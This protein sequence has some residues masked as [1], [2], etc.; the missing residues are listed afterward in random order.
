MSDNMCNYK[1]NYFSCKV[2]NISKY[3]GTKYISEAYL[4]VDKVL[5][6]FFFKL[7]KVY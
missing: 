6:L 1:C 7:F 2:I 5:K 3:I 4:F